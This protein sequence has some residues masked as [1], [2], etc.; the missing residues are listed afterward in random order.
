M[1]DFFNFKKITEKNRQKIKNLK[2]TNQNAQR[3]KKI[4]SQNDMTTMC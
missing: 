4:Y 1:Y 3:L 2:K